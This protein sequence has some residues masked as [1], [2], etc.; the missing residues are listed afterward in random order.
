MPYNL[1]V[2]R[3]LKSK[4]VKISMFIGVYCEVC[5]TVG[6]VEVA[7]RR[8]IKIKARNVSVFAELFQFN[9]RASGRSGSK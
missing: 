5:S 9:N 4:V 6:Y 1:R 3:T 8:I 7:A 2:L